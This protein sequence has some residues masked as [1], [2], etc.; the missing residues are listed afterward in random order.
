MTGERVLV[1]GAG[2][3]IGSHLVEA[4]V[5]EGCAVR[6][7]VRYN[8]E[9]R[10]GNLELLEP[11]TRE[12]V[13]VYYGDLRDREAVHKGMAGVEAVFHLGA[14]V[15]VPYSYQHPEE[16]TAVNVGG[17]LNVLTAARDLGVG[18]VVV[19]STSE[20]YG[21]A[22]YVPIDEGHPIQPQ[23]PYAASKAGADGLAVSFHRTYGLPVAIVRPFNTYGPRQSA[24][25]V[26]P[27]I[28]SQALTRPVV[29]LGAL[30]PERDLTFVD[31]TVAGFFCAWHAGEEA[32]GAPINLGTG[33]GVSIG[34]LAR[35]VIEL[36]G[37]P[38]EL[39][40]TA[41]RMRPEGSEVLALISDNSRARTLLGWEPTV[42]LEEGLRR[43]IDWVRAHLD[44]FRPERYS[45]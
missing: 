39:R 31:D 10:V 18:R 17:A 44:R 5:R 45:I 37:R 43:T 23:S 7:F 6:A 16:T 24:R 20:V 2:G 21:T 12:A 40:S 15:S 11:D 8:S 30:H 9:G 38:V 14:V 42:S 22:R 1:T 26:V 32:W 29:E 19:T 25:A 27:T 36:V 13:E 3:F 28:I 41:E 35:R 33:E 4:L 34:D